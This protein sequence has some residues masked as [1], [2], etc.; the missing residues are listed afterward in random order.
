VPHA[1]SRPHNQTRRENDTD[2]HPDLSELTNLNVWVLLVFA[3]VT[4]CVASWRVHAK[5]VMA[6][7][8]LIIVCVRRITYS[9]VWA[10][11]VGFSHFTVP[12]PPQS[13][14]VHNLSAS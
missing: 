7:N 3:R 8:N 10:L 9:G 4:V 13:V 5:C 11:F 6:N 14:A 12:E 1:L 2:P